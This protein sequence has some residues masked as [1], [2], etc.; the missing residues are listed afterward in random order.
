MVRL[1]EGRIRVR[2]ERL[3]KRRIAEDLKRSLLAVKGMGEI[4]CNLRTGSLLIF[5]DTAVA[6][7]KRILG[8]IGEAL[9]FSLSTGELPPAGSGR[10][11]S[12]L[13]HLAGM[14]RRVG[15]GGMAAA[16]ALSLLGAAAG[17]AKLHAA[18]GIVFI[19]LVGVHMCRHNKT[20]FA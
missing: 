1:M 12:P 17:G 5:F 13:P 6:N 16:L 10:K 14:A 18:A 9:G 3:K 4:V 8:I 19:A 2:D 15:K 7:S 20:L 11:E